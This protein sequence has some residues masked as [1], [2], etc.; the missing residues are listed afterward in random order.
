MGRIFSFKT[1]FY[2][3]YYLCWTSRLF[4]FIWHWY[5][6]YDF[7]IQQHF[8]AVITKTIHPIL[9]FKSSKTPNSFPFIWEGANGLA[10]KSKLWLK[11]FKR[12]ILSSYFECSN[13]SLVHYPFHI[14]ICK[15]TFQLLNQSKR[16]QNNRICHWYDSRIFP[17]DVSI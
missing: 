13:S 1:P 17:E 5:H 10:E 15:S 2:F 9:L 7:D 3:T 11:I 14:L 12:I 8:S 4:Y 6:I 16:T